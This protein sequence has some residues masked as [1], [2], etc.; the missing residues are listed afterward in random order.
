[1]LFGEHAVLRG[2]PAL[3]CAIAKRIHVQATARPDRHVEVRSAFGRYA[4]ALDTLPPDT[5]F[6]FVR[7]ALAQRRTRL[8]SG[9]ALDIESDVP[10][11]LGWGSSAA[12]TVAVLAALDELSGR[13]TS[14]ADLLAD[15]RAIIRDVQGV[16]SG[17]D[18]AASVYGGVVAFRAEPLAA[19]PLGRTF[20]LT[21]VYAGYKTPTADV[22]RRVEAARAAEPARHADLDA[23]IGRTAAAATDAAAA[24]DIV[25]LGALMNEGQRWMEA[26][27][28]CDARL[29]EIVTALRARRG[30]F[31]AKISGSGLG[32]CAVGLGETDPEG[33]PGE[34]WNLSMDPEGVRVTREPVTA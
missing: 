31:G 11:H 2:Q 28:V 34:A 8:A 16:G 26:L 1:M 4:A 12:V 17:A 27:G 23:H 13:A 20:P 14:R 25:R 24:G 29:T 19:R 18:A 15:A 3:V 10:S 5:D 22:I 9:C 21:V 7:A 32:D 33:L 6:R 30:I